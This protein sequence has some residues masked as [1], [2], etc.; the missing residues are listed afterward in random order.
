MAI[1]KRL[2]GFE[3]GTT[4]NK[5]SKSPERYSNSGA[6]GLR[7]RRAD[8]SVMLLPLNGLYSNGYHMVSPQLLRINYQKRMMQVLKGLPGVKCLVDDFLVSGRN[9]I[10]HSL[11]VLRKKALP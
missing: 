9:R 2:R 7:V 3:L 5:S 10:E 11:F 4:E 6:V 8:H 1:Y